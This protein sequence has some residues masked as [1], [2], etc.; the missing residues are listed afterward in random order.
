MRRLRRSALV[1][2]SQKSL[3]PKTIIGVTLSSPVAPPSVTS[4][5]VR[6]VGKLRGNYVAVA[7]GFGQTGFSLGAT[8]GA[9]G[10]ARPR[11]N[12]DRSGA[13]EGGFSA[14]AGHCG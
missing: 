10:T 11:A 6:S 3:I 2:S 9:Q 13:F 5:P 12:L 14:A 1:S 8:A 7:G 4:P